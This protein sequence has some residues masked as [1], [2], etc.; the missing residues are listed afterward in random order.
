LHLTRHSLLTR[1]SA[2]RDP[3]KT[4][5]SGDFAAYFDRTYHA[6]TTANASWSFD[7]RGTD[8]YVYGAAGP[9]YGSYAV[10]L[11][12]NQ[13]TQTAFA[14]ANASLPYL[15]YAAHN[16]SNA[17]THS[18]TVTNLG[19]ADAQEGSR[20]LLDYIQT[21]VQLA[22]EGASLVNST[23][24]DSNTTALSYTGT[25][26]N[27][28]DPLFSGG[29]TTYT[30]EEGATVSLKFYGTAIYMYGDANNDHGNFT[31][32]VDDF[33]V[34]QL[35]TPNGCGGAYGKF[36]E[37]TSPGLQFFQAYLDESEHTITVTNGR[38]ETGETSYFD[39]DRFVYTTPSSYIP[40]S[41]LV[42]SNMTQSGSIPAAGN[43][44]SASDSP[45]TGG[46]LPAST[47]PGFAGIAALGLVVAHMCQSFLW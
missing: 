30:N 34:R 17:S 38:A 41:A 7:F 32:K 11:D 45:G 2:P 26:S 10:D 12:G 29:T 3:S 39:L 28:S 4:T 44:P 24:E 47:V 20:M 27:N 14:A 35:R 43:S 22:P 19:A 33:P 16:L 6:T 8:L 5:T 9:S 37:K 31:V 42:D 1:A 23:V 15:L 25:W 36:C 21:T 40:Q 46:S 13:T 18:V